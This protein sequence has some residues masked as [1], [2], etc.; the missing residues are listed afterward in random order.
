MLIGVDG[1]L[2]PNMVIDDDGLTS[3]DPAHDGIDF[4]ESLEGMRVTVENP[5]VIQSTNSFGETYVVA[6]DGQGATGVAARG[7]LTLSA[8]DTNPERILV[9]SLNQ[10]PTHYTEGDHVASV[11]GV[12]GYSFDTYRV[13]TDTDPAVRTPGDLA[14]ET[15]SLVGDSDHLSIA[16]YNVENLD[17]SDNKYDILAHDIIVNLGAPDIVSLQEIQDDNGTGTGVLSANQ[18]LGNLVAALNAADPTAHYVFA[19]IDPTAENQTG[20]EPNGNIRNAF[21]YDTNRVSLVDGSLELIQGD[22]FHNS[23]NPL[24]GTF[25]FNGHDVTVVDVHSYSRGGS[26][27][28]FGANQPPVQSGDDRRTDMADAIKA[29]VDDHLATD[30]SLN[31]AVMGDF[32]GF[33]Y[34]TALQHLAAGGVL[35][36]LNGLLAPEERYSYQF[37]GNLQEFDN[38]LVTGGLLNGAQYDSVHLN[39]E[40]DPATRPTDHDPQ[41]ALF[42]LPPPNQAPTDLMLDHQEVDE[43]QPAGTIVGTL[44]A[45]D[46]PTDTLSYALADDAGGRFVVD[47]QTGV[48]TTNAAFDHEA[49]ASFSITATVTDQGG[50]STQQSFTIAVGDV[51][52]APTGLAIDHQAID[53]NAPAGTLVGTVTASDPDGD[54]LTYSLVDDAGGLFAID[55]ATGRL[56][57]TASLDYEAAHNYSVTARADDGHG[58]FTDHVFA[59]GVNDVNEAPTGL[60]LDHNGVNENLPAGTLVGTLSATDPDGN[61]IAYS[62]VDNA[63]GR[64]AVD[65]AGHVTT[66]APFD[67]ES[68][69]S[70]HITARADDGHGLHTDQI[71]A[72]AVNDVNEAPTAH[73]DSTGVNEDATSGNLWST[74]LA[75]DSDPDAGDHLTILSVDT[76]GTQGHVLF[77]AAS[78]SCATSPTPMRSTLCRPAPPRPTISATRSPTSHGLTSTATVNG[79]GDRDRRW[80]RRAMRTDRHDGHRHRRRGLLSAA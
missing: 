56:T 15:T 28:D 1:R 33:Y 59:I 7:G 47:A 20:G 44:S 8:G 21:V 18:N 72:I 80:H 3:Y 73:G 19:D 74:L 29:Y 9:D 34:E 17:F 22:A 68:G 25:A 12:L 76:T 51:N 75:N 26:D 77:D 66:N 79:D 6:S 58:L 11:T 45:T 31:F 42:D 54:S 67:F 41:V 13:L 40:F 64:F 71:F 50:L 30:P 4:Y 37:D 70:Y 48:V 60:A 46:R 5:L 43:N 36:N 55:P 53:E 14:R 16:T 10:N 62:L 63:G 27:P 39:A 61:A 32:N 35:T 78:Q 2:P 38:I 57:A 49:N 65:A 24:V 52:E 23:R 69:A